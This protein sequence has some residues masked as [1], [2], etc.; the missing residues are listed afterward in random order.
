MT[1]IAV[2]PAPDLKPIRGPS[3]LGGGTRRF[4]ELLWMLATSD[5]KTTYRGTALGYVWSLFR[6]LLLFGVLLVVFTQVVKLGSG[7]K[8]YAPMLLLNV[9]LFTFFSE[10]TTAAVTSVAN[11]EQIVR[12]TQFP[13]LVIP[14]AV[15]LNAV[16]HLLLNLVVVMIFIV[17]YGVDP[18][19]DWLW[20]P[21]I[22][23]LL[24]LI[25]CAFSVGLSVLYV[26]F[27]D[28]A[29]IWSVVAL[30][31]FYGTPILYPIEQ[32]PESFRFVIMLNPLTP[33]FEQTRHW[34]IDPAA[35][36]AVE[37]IG[38]WAKMLA[39]I[40]LFAAICGLGAW[41]FGREA[42]RVAENL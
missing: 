39:P 7:V 15:V 12:K 24:L 21:V 40:G 26:R 42:P 28:T 2:E 31:L 4:F 41:L 5:F 27:R 1:E 19:W 18:T 16:F 17:A 25:T 11:K 20:M 34:I 32:V 36:S 35:P 6:P 33:L 38:S 13:R 30:V 22:I 14:L 8:N 3:A 29:I 9:M 37:A 10:A 23:A